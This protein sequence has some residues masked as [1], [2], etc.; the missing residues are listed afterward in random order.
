M[1]LLRQVSQVAVGGDCKLLEQEIVELGRFIQLMRAASESS[2]FLV[3]C[4]LWQGMELGVS[5]HFPSKE[6]SLTDSTLGKQS[7]KVI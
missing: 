1:N 5:R 2:G 7:I 6:T 3:L 4:R